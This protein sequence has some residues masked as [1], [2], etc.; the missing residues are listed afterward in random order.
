MSRCTF[1]DPKR[2]QCWH[3]EDH[4]GR[5]MVAGASVGD[6]CP[7][8]HPDNGTRC[9]RPAGHKGAHRGRLWL[10]W[11]SETQGELPL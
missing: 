4:V 5:H 6:L 3:S 7:T 9:E 2:G 1:T 8:A 10:F 11:A